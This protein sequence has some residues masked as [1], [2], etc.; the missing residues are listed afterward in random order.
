MKNL[1]FANDRIYQIWIAVKLVL[2]DVVEHFQEK[3]HQMMIA[4][5]AK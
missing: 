2:D 1:S 3:E 5:V 4:R